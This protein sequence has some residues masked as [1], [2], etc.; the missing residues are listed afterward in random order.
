MRLYLVLLS[1]FGT[2]WC[3]KY[4]V[5]LYVYIS[6]FCVIMWTYVLFILFNRLNCQYLG[7]ISTL[8]SFLEDPVIMLGP[9]FQLFMIGEFF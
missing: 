5:G 7:V 1:F 8:F 2:M 9:G 4:V 3:N 6:S